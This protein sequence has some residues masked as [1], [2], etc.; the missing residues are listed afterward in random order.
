MASTSFNTYLYFKAIGQQSNDDCM[1]QAIIMRITQA[2]CYVMVQKYGLEGLLQ[3]VEAQCFPEKEYCIMN[4]KEVKTFE[5]VKVE[6]KAQ[7][8]EFRRTVSLV[9]RGA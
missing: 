2:G 1:Q 5:R 7:M 3:G 9:Y 4:G 6:I 8:V